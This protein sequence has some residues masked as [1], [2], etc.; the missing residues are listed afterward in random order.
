MTFDTQDFFE[1]RDVFNSLEL[2]WD[3]LRT[4]PT[5]MLGRIKMKTLDKY[6][7]AR[8]Q[9]DDAVDLFVTSNRILPPTSPI[10]SDTT[11]A[12]RWSHFKRALP[13]RSSTHFS[14]HRSPSHFVVCCFA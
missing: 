13:S 1:N 4:L 11:V 10:P 3:L 2:G 12:R 5:N 7:A 9:S 8:A 6:V 14:K